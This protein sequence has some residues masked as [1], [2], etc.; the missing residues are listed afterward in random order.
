MFGILNVFYHYIID[1]IRCQFRNADKYASISRYER[2]NPLQCPCCS[3]AVSI[4]CLLDTETG[5][6]TEIMRFDRLIET[7]FF[8]GEHELLYNEG[9]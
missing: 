1:L 3:E 5:A 2:S 4:L 9:S 8:R 6:N 7:P